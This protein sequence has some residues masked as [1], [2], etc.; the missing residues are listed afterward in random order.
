MGTKIIITQIAHCTAS[1]VGIATLLEQRQID[2]FWAQWN[3]SVRITP[4]LVIA[5]L[6]FV[7]LIVYAAVAYRRARTV[8][9]SATQNGAVQQDAKEVRR[10]Q[11]RTAKKRFAQTCI[12]IPARTQARLCNLAILVYI[13]L[14]LHFLLFSRTPNA[15]SAVQLVPFQWYNGVWHESQVIGAAANTALFVPF[16]FLLRCKRFSLHNGLFVLLGT[17]LF[18]EIMQYITLLGDF[19]TENLITTVLGGCVG[20]FLCSKINSRL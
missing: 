8:Q 15:S 17:S 12:C 9:K 2:K 11:P 10:R 18:C 5:L 1:A 20:W 16:G 6:L 13:L 19:K 4:A 3:E 7:V 14:V